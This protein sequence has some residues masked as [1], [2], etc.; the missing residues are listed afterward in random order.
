MTTDLK[1]T[2]WDRIEDVQA[3]LL[4]TGGTR[5]VPMSP[6]ARKDDKAIWFIT[7]EGTAANEAAK[8][9]AKATFNVAD[10]KA[11]LFATIDGTLEQSHDKAKLDELWSPVASAWF[12]EGQEDKDV[13]LI[14]FTPSDAEV[15]ATDGGAKFLYE[16]AKAHVTEEKPD[17]G[18][19]GR[20]MF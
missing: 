3:G 16:I 2:F 15:W 14:R 6:M 17:M 19:H 7:A 13:R 8:T 4:E 5:P 12:E 11:H 18:D 20:V 9:G 1:D 10:P